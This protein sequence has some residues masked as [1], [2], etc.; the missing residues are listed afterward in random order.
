M[1]IGL[2]NDHRAYNVK[3]E[4]KS[5]LDDYEIIDYGCFSNDM[6]DYPKYAITLATAVVNKDVDLGIV[7]CGTGIGVSIAANKVKKIRCAKI[8]NVDEARSAK[9]HN[10]ANVLAF[11]AQSH[12]A[13]EIKE[14]IDIFINSTF[15]I[16]PRYKMR[17]E[18]VEKYEE[19]NEY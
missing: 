17:I 5:L 12:T 7:M 18:Q 10:N 6:V 15:N 11:S 14:M 19:T 8:D 1:K 16:N 13:K 9:E 4:L 3:E 2:A